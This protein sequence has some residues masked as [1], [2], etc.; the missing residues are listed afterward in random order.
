MTPE[1]F[2]PTHHI[3]SIRHPS[4]QYTVSK[5]TPGADKDAISL[6]AFKST[7][8]S[9]VVAMITADDV[10]V[11]TPW[12]SIESVAV[13]PCLEDGTTLNSLL[14]KVKEMSEP[15]DLAREGRVGIQAHDGRI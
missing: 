13:V 15:E 9:D 11:I 4:G 6:A 5:I 10:L 1:E 8:P 12:T 7:S 3:V 2:E 14:R